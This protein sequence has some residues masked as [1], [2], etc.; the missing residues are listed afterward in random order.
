MTCEAYIIAWNEAEL[1][2]LTVAHYQQ[3]C[4]KI[5]VFDNHS[6]D[7]TRDI[8]TY[9]G[10]EVRLFGIPGVL[11]D[12]EYLRI[13]NFAWKGSKADW[14]IVV[15]CDE[16]LWHPNI[17]KIYSPLWDAHS[18]GHSFFA[19]QGWDVVSHHPAAFSITS[20]KTGYANDNYSKSVI[21]NPRMIREIGY[22]YGCHQAKPVGLIRYSPHL[23]M[24][25]HYSNIG[26]PER[27]CR[28][29]AAYRA[30]LSEN[31][32]RWG[33]GIHY[34]YSDEQRIKEWN[35]KY[36]KSSVFSQGLYY[37]PEGRTKV[38]IVAK[39]A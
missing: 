21:F 7:G 1:I 24:L 22:V 20:Q 11:D 28:R 35:D 33:L 15:D 13:K 23:L 25:F 14:V 12:K 17:H 19:T 29:H 36:E 8:A 37:S 31:N 9:M 16:I 2:G 4:T 5:I 18:S 39:Y 32:K 27:L 26:G 3:F 34:T 38:P 30:R 10:A 6:T